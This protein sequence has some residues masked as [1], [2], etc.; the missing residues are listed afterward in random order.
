MALLIR[1]LA[2]AVTAMYLGVMILGHRDAGRPLY[3][4]D[5]LAIGIA[6]TGCLIFAF[7]GL[8]KKPRGRS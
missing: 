8:S 4:A 2:V 1:L 6:I 3:V 5:W 7:A